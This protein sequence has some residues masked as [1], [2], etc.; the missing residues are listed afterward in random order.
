MPRTYMM[1][2]TAIRTKHHFQSRAKGGAAWRG[3]KKSTAKK[4]LGGGGK[5]KKK[6]ACKRVTVCTGSEVR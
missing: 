1:G 4:A 6:S 5:T 3:E 2:Q